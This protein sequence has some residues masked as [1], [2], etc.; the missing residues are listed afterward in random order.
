MDTQPAQLAHFEYEP[1]S[2]STLATVPERYGRRPLS[3]RVTAALASVLACRARAKDIRQSAE[4]LFGLPGHW[5]A[6]GIDSTWP[7]AIKRLIRVAEAEATAHVREAAEAWRADRRTR[8]TF[9]ALIDGLGFGAVWYAA[10][11]RSLCERY[12]LRASLQAEQNALGVV[13]SVDGGR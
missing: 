6:G 5:E 2:T 7:P 1:L 11:D 3:P 13:A 9:R 8:P 12:D 10:L 4:A